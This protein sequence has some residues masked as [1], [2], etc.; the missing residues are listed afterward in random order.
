VRPFA[1]ARPATV[2]FAAP[3]APAVARRPVLLRPPRGAAVWRW[4]ASTWRRP[5]SAPRSRCTTA[6]APWRCRRCSDA[7]SR[8][9]R[10]LFNPE[11]KSTHRPGH[12]DALRRHRPLGDRASSLRRRRP[13]TS[14]RRRPTSRRGRGRQGGQDLRLEVAL[15][16]AAVLV[17]G[18][19][20]SALA[21]RTWASSA[22]ARSSPNFII[23][24]DAD[25]DAPVSPEYVPSPSHPLVAARARTTSSTSRR[26]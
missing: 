13:S 16:G 11:G 12:L 7:S 20:S 1:P 24:S 2:R 14:A 25:V 4:R 22:A 23:G 18:G 17:F 8:A 19:L 5:A 3:P 21:C 9:A 15:A 26:A 6:R 10:H